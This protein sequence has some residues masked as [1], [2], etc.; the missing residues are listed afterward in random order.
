MLRSQIW[1]EISAPPR[2]ILAR[3]QGRA[4]QAHCLEIAQITIGEITVHMIDH[5]L[6][7]MPGLEP[8]AITDIL[9]FV[10]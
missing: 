10:A 5:E 8:T 4:V 3:D 1:F 2:Q 7:G 6:A 9:F